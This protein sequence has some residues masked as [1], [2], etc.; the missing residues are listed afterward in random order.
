MPCQTLDSMRGIPRSHR[1]ARS[2]P[3]T[4][5]RR[6]RTIIAPSRRKGFCSQRRDVVD[7]NGAGPGFFHVGLGYSDPVGVD[8]GF[9]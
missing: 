4:L 5:E 9:G 2:R 8:A 6:G 1:Y 7:E 3:L